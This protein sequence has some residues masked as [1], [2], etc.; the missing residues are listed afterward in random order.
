MI[1]DIRTSSWGWTILC[2]RAR[3]LE[4]ERE[5]RAGGDRA[6]RVLLQ[7]RRDGR[8]VDDR[9]APLVERDPLRQELGAEPV[10]LARDRVHADSFHLGGRGRTA[11]LPP[12][13]RPR[14]WRSTSSAKTSSA[15]ATKRAAPSGCLQAPR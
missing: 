6:L 4:Q 1:T 8:R 14:R 5:H 10:A 12:L 7:A 13:Q 9:V 15:L 3:L 11:R 2:R